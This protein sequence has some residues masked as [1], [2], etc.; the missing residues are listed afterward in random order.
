MPAK[1]IQKFCDANDISRARYYGMKA[2]GLGPREMNNGS[3][4]T[5]TDEAE[6]EWR[7]LLEV[8]TAI[9]DLPEGKEQDVQAAVHMLFPREEIP[10]AIWRK[11]WARAPLERAKHVQREA[12]R[13]RVIEQRKARRVQQLA[14]G[15]G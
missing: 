13:R 11:A 4:V 10:A 12:S 15:E 14:E 3:R 5:I 2:E 6:T 7:I 1:S 8:L 9:V